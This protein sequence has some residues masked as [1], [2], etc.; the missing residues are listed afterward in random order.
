MA[1]YCF[2]GQDFKFYLTGCI[3]KSVGVV[4]ERNR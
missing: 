1:V 3:S 2:D 4:E